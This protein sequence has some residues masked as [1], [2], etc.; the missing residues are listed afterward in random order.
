MR[1]ISLLLLISLILTGC[2]SISYARKPHLM[3]NDSLYGMAEPDAYS[4]ESMINSL[5][6]LGTIKESV[7]S[8]EL[9]TRNFQSNLQS[10]IGM[11]LYAEIDRRIQTIYVRVGKDSDDDEFL[12]YYFSSSIN[13]I[14]SDYNHF[15]NR[16]GIVSRED[17]N[18]IEGIESN[19]QKVLK[20]TEVNDLLIVLD[21]KDTYFKVTAPYSL[22]KTPGYVPAN[23]LSFDENDLKRGNQGELNNTDAYDEKD[24]RVIGK[25]SGVGII[26][27]RDGA[28]ALFE[29]PEETPFWVLISQISFEL[30]SPQ[31]N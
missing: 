16:T 24:G 14:D 25:K 8:S 4:Y 3:Y 6:K 27:Q 5:I 15:Q 12:K 26:L 19:E 22:L 17:I 13:S 29:L 31:L 28:W 30:S 21:I 1:V 11:E 23:S 9:P 2:N 18:I 10:Y 20:H 7:S